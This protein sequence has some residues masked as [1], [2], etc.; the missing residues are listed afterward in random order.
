[1]ENEII[2]LKLNGLSWQ[3]VAE[4]VGLPYDRVRTIARRSSRYGEIQGSSVNG[5]SEID[6][7]NY[8][9]DGSISSFIRTRLDSKQTFT[10]D[11][12]LELHGFDPTEF[13][14]KTITSNEWTTPIEGQSFYNYQSKIV[15]EPLTG[16]EIDKLVDCL[17]ES[18]KPVYLDLVGVGENNL[19][20]PLADLHFGITTLDM[21][22]PK[23]A[24]VV[25]VIKNG[26]KTIVIEQVGDLFHSSQMK[27]SQTIKGTL[28]DEVDMPRAVEDA[29]TFFDVILSSALRNAKEV[30]IEHAGGNHSDNLEYM[31]LVYLEARYP[32]V[33]VNYHNDYRTAYTL[34]NV[35]IMLSHGNTVKLNKLPMMFANEYPLMWA[36][37][38]TKEVH[39]GHKHSFEKELDGVILRQFGTPKP[40]DSYEIMNG[41]TTN[42]KV[43]QL[44]E[45][46]EDRP[47]VIYEV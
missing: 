36:N 7:K 46:D 6:K 44:I 28:L 2:D 21:V 12:L 9:E 8:R 30:V 20:I 10:K 23:L 17:K 39:T 33:K 13:K 27:S 3:E 45:Y 47:R 31:F 14:I 37:C 38:E 34:D 32:Q 40:S 35:G 25:D 1:M 18:V 42:R 16:N 41:W 19:V 15:A 11:E 5:Y 29:K 24:E 4:E 26:Y 43:I 22:K